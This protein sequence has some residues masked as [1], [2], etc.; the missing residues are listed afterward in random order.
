MPKEIKTFEQY[1]HWVK[2][3][4][5]G[6]TYQDKVLISLEFNKAYNSLFEKTASCIVI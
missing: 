4:L 3:T 6:K 2:T 5:E 1:R